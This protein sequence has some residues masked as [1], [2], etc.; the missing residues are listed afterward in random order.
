[1]LLRGLP[2][3]YKWGPLWQTSRRNPLG[4]SKLYL[5]KTPFWHLLYECPCCTLN[6]ILFW[7]DLPPPGNTPFERMILKIN[8]CIYLF[9]WHV[10]E[11][12]LYPW[13]RLVV[14]SMYIIKCLALWVQ[15]RWK[16]CWRKDDQNHAIW[17]L[18][19]F[20]FNH[21]VFGARCFI[22]YLTL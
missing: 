2:K 15:Y 6:A 14:K 11:D 21:A 17:L 19:G 18:Q 20:F 7:N 8:L 1:M 12:L 16:F 9:Q 4:K 13:L 3:T 22:G 10:D 5:M